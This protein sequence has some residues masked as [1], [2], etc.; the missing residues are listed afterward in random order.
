MYNAGAGL[1]AT[2][3]ALAK[4]SIW[5]QSQLVII[6]S[7]STDATVDV[8]RQYGANVMEIAP[9][10]FDHGSTRNL[11]AGMLD[12]EFIIFLTQDA[13]CADDNTLANLIKP[14]VDDPR[15][16]VSYGAQIPQPGSDPLD[17]FARRFNYPDTPALKTLADLPRLGIK[18]YFC[19]N[20]CAAYRREIFDQ[21]GGFENGVSTNEDMLFAAKAIHA[22]YGVYY[23][24]GAKVYHSHAYT[25]ASLFARYRAIGR[26][27]KNHPQLLSAA[28]KKEGFTF[29]TSGL[30]Y[31]LSRGQFWQACRLIAQ[32]FVKFLAFKVA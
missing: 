10:D 24:A 5:A 31:F 8:A 12:A 16:A 3:D 19:S 7:G 27:F 28:P 18:T 11:A 4:Q 1:G 30:K 9:K 22:G 32:A 15:V 23:A 13:I 2:L 26:F 25:L 6:D 14:L 29:L 20:S 17:A 21:L